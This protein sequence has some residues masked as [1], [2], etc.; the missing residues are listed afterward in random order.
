MALL[1]TSFPKE[2]YLASAAAI[3]VLWLTAGFATSA[4]ST[5]IQT[6]RAADVSTHL[7]FPVPGLLGRALPPLTLTFGVGRLR[8]RRTQVTLELGVHAG[9]AALAALFVFALV[10]AGLV[11]EIT[12]LAAL[13]RQRDDPVTVALVFGCVSVLALLSGLVLLVSLVAGSKAATGTP[14]PTPPELPRG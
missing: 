2:F 4:I 10:L 14:T 8:M 1:A 7:H 5:V 3:P 12:S 9:N 11:G 6:L 13:L